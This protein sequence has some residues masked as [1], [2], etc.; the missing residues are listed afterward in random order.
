M[1]RR[2]GDVPVSEWRVWG[3]ER[4]E[5]CSSEQLVQGH[6]AEAGNRL[7]ICKKG[8]IVDLDL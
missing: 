6:W 7:Q 4:S 5:T 3:G 1:K 2:D 8:L